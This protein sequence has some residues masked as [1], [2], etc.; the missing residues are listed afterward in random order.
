MIFADGCSIQVV[1]LAAKASQVA[2]F[3]DEWCSRVSTLSYANVQRPH[4]LLEK[5]LYQ[6]LS[7]ASEGAP[8]KKFR[9]KAKN[10][11]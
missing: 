2:A 1:R 6:S 5:L 3:G 8:K 4:E 7:K 9:I 11:S 10:R